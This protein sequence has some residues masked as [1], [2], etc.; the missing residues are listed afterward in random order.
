MDSVNL[1]LGVQDFF[2]VGAGMRK[3]LE[4][5]RHSFERWRY[6]HEDPR[7]ICY[8]PELNEALTVII[9]RPITKSRRIRPDIA[10]HYSTSPPD[11]RPVYH[12]APEK[13]F[14]PS[15]LPLPSPFPAVCIQANLICRA[16]CTTC[17]R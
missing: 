9:E 11:L 8:L 17:A 3:V 10:E 15:W 4:Y 12:P 13:T 2:P 5:H 1:R 6:L 14:A 7:E 16:P